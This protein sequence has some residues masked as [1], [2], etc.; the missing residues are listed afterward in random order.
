MRLMYRLGQYAEDFVTSEPAIDKVCIR[1]IS[2]VYGIL[3]GA[4]YNSRLVSLPAQD[5][6]A[7]RLFE[8]RSRLK[9][10]LLTCYPPKNRLLERLC[11]PQRNKFAFEFTLPES[12]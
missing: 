7:G 1:R 8:G 2:T 10:F 6:P 12:L 9:F 11:Q 4:S 3:N 5:L